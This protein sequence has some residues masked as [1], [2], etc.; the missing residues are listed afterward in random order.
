[1]EGPTHAFGG[2]AMVTAL[3]GTGQFTVD[4]TDF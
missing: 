1:M 2:D 3:D 4:G